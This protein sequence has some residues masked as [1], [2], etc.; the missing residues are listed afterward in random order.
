MEHE[1][2]QYLVSD[3]FPDFTQ[4]FFLTRVKCRMCVCV[5]NGTLAK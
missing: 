3:L 1:S 2:N 5:Y 4:A